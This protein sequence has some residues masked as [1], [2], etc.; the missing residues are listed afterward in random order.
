MICTQTIAKIIINLTMDNGEIMI[1]IARRSKVVSDQTKSDQVFTV[2]K[3]DFERLNS[4]KA[5][6]SNQG[7]GDKKVTKSPSSPT[8]ALGI[9]Y[10]FQNREECK[11]QNCPYQHVT[12]RNSDNLQMAPYRGNNSKQGSHGGGRANIS[13]SYYQDDYRPYEEHRRDRESYEYH[14]KNYPNSHTNIHRPRDPAPDT[15][16]FMGRHGISACIPE[17]GTSEG[18][19]QNF[20]DMISRF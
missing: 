4:W 17:P 7:N 1:I 9:C 12:R 14:Y 11:R 18:C 10:D 8:K 6:K 2:S 3:A 5:N 20:H 16:F 15:N 19:E 13:R